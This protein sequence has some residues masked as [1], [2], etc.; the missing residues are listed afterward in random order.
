MK[1]KKILCLAMTAVIGVGCLA[2]CGEKQTS[3]AD[4]TVVTVWG[5]GAGVNVEANFAKKFNETIGAEKHIRIDFQAKEGDI[6]QQVE[7]ALQSRKAPDIFPTG[8]VKEMA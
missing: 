4:T 5:G 3:D 2:G 7:V 1:V 6:Q 8:K